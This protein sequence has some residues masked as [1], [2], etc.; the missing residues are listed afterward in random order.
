MA[1]KQSRTA[2]RRAELVPLAVIGRALQVFAY[3][4]VSSDIQ[5]EDETIKVQVTK[6]EGTIRV[7]ENSELPLRDQLKLL[8]SFWDNGVS[9]TLSLEE[10]PEGKRLVNQICSRGSMLCAGNCVDRNV[11]DQVW[12]TKLDRLAR[13]LQILIDIEAF[14]R[15]HNVALICMDPSIDTSTAT[16]RLVFSVLASIAEWER[17]TILER[18]TNGK[19]QKASEG[20]WVGGRKAF[21]LKT[22]EDGY[23]IV[24][25]TFVEQC[26]MAAYQ[27]VQSVFENIALHGST[28][29]REAQRIGMSD[30]RVGLMLHNPRY[31]GEGGIIGS[32]GSWTNADSNPPPQVVTPALWE[33]AQVALIANRKNSSRHRHYDYLLSQLLICHEPNGEGICGRKFIGRTEKRHTYRPEYTYYYC[34]RTMRVPGVPSQAGCTAK[35]LRAQDAEDA[36]WNH[37]ER[38]LRNPTAYYLEQA[39]QDDRREA[40]LKDLRLELTHIVD[41]LQRLASARD[42]V[43]VAFEEGF[44][45]REEAKIRVTE[46]NEQATS[47]E[48]RRAAIQMQ[49][50]SM[51]LNAIDQQRSVLAIANIGE[52]LDDINARNDRKLKAALIKQIVKAPIEVRTVEGRPV[53]RVTFA[54]GAEI[55]LSS[56]SIDRRIGR[57]EW[58]NRRDNSS[59]FS[60]LADIALPRTTMGPKP[61][62]KESLA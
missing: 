52:E 32:D 24:D 18:T 17:E 58:D 1:P 37:V 51:S 41:R 25:D 31:K 55:D 36:V 46:I 30:R 19:H 27:V 2:R 50:R 43:S 48:E 4:R 39:E 57:V 59:S 28:T 16:G 10:R 12:I 6:L 56:A 29:W 49:I 54:V 60:V 61:G 40:L 42:N 11:V 35:M 23:L 53:M 3:G 62:W 33:A 47:L 22:D 26:G 20:K 45:T 5:R 9:G 38:I 21:G 7:R 34:S 13:K 44:R 15:R 14:L 8:E